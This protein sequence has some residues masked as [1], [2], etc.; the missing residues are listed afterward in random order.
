MK[1][2]GLFL[3]LIVPLGVW[4]AISLYG[5]PHVAL[6]YRFHDN[7]RPHDPRVSRVYVSCD[8]L[9]W[10][11]WQT[12]LADRGTCPWVRFLRTEEL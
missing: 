2:A 5:T 1:I 7:G 12:L 8:Y 10:H 9:G 4:L 11:G 6:S 3:W